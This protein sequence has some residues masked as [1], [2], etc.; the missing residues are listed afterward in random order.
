VSE[1]QTNPA[2]WAS[3]PSGRHE[4]RYWNGAAWTDFVADHSV[5]GVDPV[6][7]LSSVGTSPTFAPVAARGEPQFAAHRTDPTAVMGRRYLAFFIDVLI[8]LAAFAIIF[9]PLATRR[10]VDQT[11]QLPGCH[12]SFVN[13]NEIRCDGR[14]VFVI[15]D[16]VYE[17]DGGATIVLSIAFTLLYFGVLEGLAGATLGKR[18]VGLRVVKEDGSIE[19]IGNG[20][21]RWILFA[22]D[23]PLSLFLCGVITSSVARGHRRLGDSAAKTYVVAASD[24]GRPITW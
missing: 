12:R 8:S 5:Q 19:G 2:R 16:T 6:S 1:V 20:L 18:V 11:L 7:G 3:D 17:A 14:T 23:G 9:F 24:V 21:I 4:Y 22:I 10:T 15:N 13:S